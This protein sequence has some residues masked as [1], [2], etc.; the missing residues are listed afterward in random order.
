MAET[1]KGD[2]KARPAF[3]LAERTATFG[4]SIIAFA[5]SLPRSPATDPL[6]RQVVRSGTSVGANYCEADEAPSR[7]DFRYK[8]SVCKKEIKETKH[9][10]R[11]I[12]AAH[13]PARTEA[14]RL[15]EEAGELLRIFAAIYRNTEA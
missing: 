6:I 2:G 12:V 11:M 4:E 14:A 15:W 5:K 9:W 7:K 13:P 8:V 3:D 10:L 1:A